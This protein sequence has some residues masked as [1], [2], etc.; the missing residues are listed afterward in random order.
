[1]ELEMDCLTPRNF[2][3]KFAAT[4]VSSAPKYMNLQGWSLKVKF[5]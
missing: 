2:Y 1:M 3:R 4:N 5:I